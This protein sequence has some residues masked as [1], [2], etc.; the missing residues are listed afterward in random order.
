M[1]H[2]FVKLGALAVATTR[3]VTRGAQLAYRAT[4]AGGRKLV[5]ARVTRL[6]W[7]ATLRSARIAALTALVA[8]C[9]LGAGWLCFHR[10][11]PGTVGVQ[12]VNFGGGGIVRRDFTSGLHFSVRGWHSWHDVDARTQLL[13]FSWSAEPCDAEY[14]KVR[15]ADGNYVRVGLAVPFRVRTGEAHLLVEQGLKSTYRQRVMNTVEKILTSEFARLR[16]EEYADSTQRLELVARALPLLNADLA[17][18]HVEATDVLIEHFRFNNEYENR[19]QQAQ[20]DAL[21]AVVSGTTEANLAEQALIDQTLRDITEDEATLSIELT[22]DIER[23]YHAGRK[24]IEARLAEARYY[25]QTRHAEGEAEFQRLVAAGERELAQAEALW[26]S[27]ENESYSTPG[28][29]VLLARTAA[30]NLNVDKVTLNSN[31][32]RQPS[33]FDLDGL[34]R[35]FVGPSHVAREGARAQ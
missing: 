1:K 30:R 19:Q 12:Q 6:A 9:L 2:V 22:R 29:R 16:T 7:R 27:A 34:V 11:L 33:L 26:T 31:D 18:L 5:H 8:A 15:T 3:L 23:A 21:K 25:D 13:A 14:L 28:G 20:Y 10:V 32:P 35:M 4:L 17:A 24:G